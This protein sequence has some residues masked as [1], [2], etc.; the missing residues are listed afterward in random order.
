MNVENMFILPSNKSK[1]K[2]KAKD[3]MITNEDLLIK[4]LTFLEFWKQKKANKKATVFII[5]S[6]Y[7]IIANKKI[8]ITKEKENSE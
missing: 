2:E 6:L 5:K 7:K 8:D 1:K 3:L 4:L